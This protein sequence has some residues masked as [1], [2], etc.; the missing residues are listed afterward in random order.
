[1][2]QISQIFFAKIRDI[3]VVRILIGAEDES[4]LLD[5]SNK[6]P[7]RHVRFDY[8]QFYLRNEPKTKS[9]SFWLA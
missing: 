8:T 5:A 4:L 7:S 1:M 3:C 2:T 9:L 6:Y